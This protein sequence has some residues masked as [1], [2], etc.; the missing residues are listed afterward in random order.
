M[1]AHVLR[2]GLSMTSFCMA[3]ARAA[4]N[5]CSATGGVTTIASRPEK[6]PEAHRLLSIILVIMAHVL[7]ADFS[8]TDFCMAVARAAPDPPQR[9]RVSTNKG[10]QPHG[11]PE[12]HRLFLLRLESI[13]AG[14]ANRASSYMN[15]GAKFSPSPW[16][17]LSLTV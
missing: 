13:S 16:S 4:P 7:L 9:G 1:M 11:D 14:I 8:M 5:L 10:K 3:V 12:A 2:A 17:V 6:N 15:T